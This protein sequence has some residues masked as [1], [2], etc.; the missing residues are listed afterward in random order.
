M[1]FL[2]TVDISGNEG[3]DSKTE[4]FAKD[5]RPAN[6]PQAGKRKHPWRPTETLVAVILRE[7]LGGWPLRSYQATSLRV[8]TQPLPCHM[9]FLLLERPQCLNSGGGLIMVFGRT[10]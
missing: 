6:F 9:F 2:Q 3:T 8:A 7:E 10:L 1:A 4:G 5:A